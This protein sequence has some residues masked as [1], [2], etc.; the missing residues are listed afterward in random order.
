MWWQ[1]G[2]NWWWPGMIIEMI[3][4]WGLVAW[5][6]IAL[7]RYL[8]NTSGRA[9]PG[10]PERRSSAEDTLAERFARGEID[11][12]EYLNR[13]NVLRSVQRDPAGRQ[14]AQTWRETRGT[15]QKKGPSA[16]STAMAAKEL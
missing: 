12:D 1:D 8:S 14:D 7:F 5:G 13:L 9:W 3:V 10:L 4:F 11:N 2:W 15:G 6:L 16:G